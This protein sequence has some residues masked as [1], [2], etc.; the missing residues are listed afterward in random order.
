ML[1]LLTARV[2][3]DASIADL[4]L[5]LAIKCKCSRRGLVN[6]ISRYFPDR[7]F[8]V[9]TLLVS[10]HDTV[11]GLEE[12]IL[13]KKEAIDLYERE[14]SRS[15]DDMEW[16][17]L[18]HDASYKISRSL[19]GRAFRG[20]APTHPD[21]LH[22]VRAFL[23]IT[24]APVNFPMQFS[25][26]AICFS[27]DT[28]EVLPLNARKTTS[29]LFIDSPFNLVGAV[30]GVLPNILAIGEDPAHLIFRVEACAGRRR[31]KLSASLLALQLKRRPPKPPRNHVY[32]WRTSE[33]DDLIKWDS[34]DVTD[35]N[36]TCVSY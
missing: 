22:T 33:K 5:S 25:E 6:E 18:S 21:D 8:G 27:S 32:Y 28:E 9:P 11:V 35:Y 4:I 29:F 24:G 34:V 26:S 13:S 1:P 12:E 14:I 23:G 3:T 7:G 31:V 30:R 10:Q 15:S 20:T 17:I 2:Y 19:I 16:A 36:L